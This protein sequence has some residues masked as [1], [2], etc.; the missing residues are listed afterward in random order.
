M[1]HIAHCVLLT[2]MQKKINKTPCPINHLTLNAFYLYATSHQK[3]PPPDRAKVLR[4]IRTW[5]SCVVP[6]TLVK[7]LQHTTSG[8]HHTLHADRLVFS[9]PFSHSALYQGVSGCRVSGTISAGPRPT[10][11]CSN[12]S[13]NTNAPTPP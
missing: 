5:P 1:I 2:L 13:R 11:Q 6:L 8:P 9:D 4:L 3:A 10:N 7:R 12:S